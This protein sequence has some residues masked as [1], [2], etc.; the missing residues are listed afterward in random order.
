[1]INLEDFRS[2]VN[3]TKEVTVEHYLFKNM[4]NFYHLLD[5]L[6]GNNGKPYTREYCE[7]LAA[8]CYLNIVTALIMSNNP[9]DEI[10][11]EVEESYNLMKENLNTSEEI[12]IIQAFNGESDQDF[13][14]QGRLASI[15]YLLERKFG[16][17]WENLVNA[18][19]S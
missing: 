6:S 4:V 18:L 10:S 12:K 3:L 11:N 13:D 8:T 7:F 14:F 2:K 15:F 17:T 1:M 16:T 19:K 9:L 5:I